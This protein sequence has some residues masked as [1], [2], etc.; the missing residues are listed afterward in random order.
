MV[1]DLSSGVLSIAIP[2]WSNFGE[3]KVTK[4]SEMFVM[5]EFLFSKRQSVD[6]INKS[7]CDASEGRENHCRLGSLR[8]PL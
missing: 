8:T 2:R 7:A 3:A 1:G 6:I 4:K 5:A